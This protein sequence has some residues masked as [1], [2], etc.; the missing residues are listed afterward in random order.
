[1]LETMR[2]FGP[3]DG[4]SLGHIAQCG[5]S[6]IVTALHDVPPERAWTPEA[7]MARKSLIEAAGLEWSVVESIP[8]HDSIK[9]GGEGA[10]GFIDVWLESLHAVAEAGIRVI[11]YNFM[12]VL[13]W[14]RT[15]LDHPVGNG[16]TALRFDAT[17]FAAFDLHI[18]KRAGAEADYSTERRKAAADYAGKLDESGAGQLTDAIIAGLPGGMSGSHD[19]DG[20]RE[21]IALYRDISR[22][23]L[24]KNLIAFQNA[25]APEAERLGVRLAIHPDDPPRSL[26]GLP[27]CV[28]TREDFRRMFQEAPS[29]ANGL[30]WCLGS[31]SAGDPAD[32][33]A[34]G[35]DHADRI[36]FAH[37]R[38]VRKD[39]DDP[40]SF[41]EAAHLEGEVPLVKAVDFLLREEA[42]RGE[43]IPMRPDH[44]WRMIDDLGKRIN[45]GYG[46][47]GRMRGLAELRGVAAGLAYA[48]TG[49]A[50]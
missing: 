40:E 2:W 8:V 36:Y 44:G 15:D 22:E 20:L 3:Q 6:G 30:T 28:S 9:R 5:A 50:G 23:D 41:Q 33:L 49:V 29:R 46:V 48:R 38:V 4:V 43:Q 7:V 13:D 18:L 17:A 31:L 1:M 45:P 16:A 14:T 35:D 26:L 12:P 24:L 10:G 47:I 11:C 37:L 21:A 34:I 27:R 32:A 39:R 42:R 19:L 25:V